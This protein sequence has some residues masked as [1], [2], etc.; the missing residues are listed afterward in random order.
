MPNFFVVMEN[1]RNVDKLSGYIIKLALFAIVVVLCWYFKNVLIYIAAAFVVS[2][3]GQPIMKVLRK[4]TIKKK[5]AP[6][7]LLAIVTLLLIFVFLILVITQIIPLVS[8]IIRDASALNVQSYFAENPLD[9][10][11][12]W[13]QATFP[14]LGKEFDLVT[15]I[16]DKLKGAVS[17]G[18]VSGFVS[19]V[20]SLVSSAFVGLFSVVFISFFFIKDGDMFEK[21]VCAL[22]PD[23]IEQ[24][25]KKTLHDIQQLLSRYFVGLL[26]EMLGVALV[27]FLGLWLVARINFNY[28]IGIAFIA[29]LLNVIP[30]VG[31]LMG[32][33]IGV[34]LGVVWKLGTGGGIGVHI[35]FFALIVLG[36]MLAAQLIDNFIYQPVIYSTSIKAHPLEIFIV[37]LMAGHIG[38][39][40]GMLV[41]IPCYTVVRVVAIRFF[42]RFKAIQR[43]IPDL[44]EEDKMIESEE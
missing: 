11:N 5:P 10:V 16:I 43:L 35:W 2:L 32:E 14:S 8:S 24:T 6:D 42:Y 31:P 25:T 4:I 7:W 33:L 30:Y 26:I 41:A 28:A 12:D 38:G 19:S 13:L 39:V 22:V 34:V 36:I 17:L 1:E 27:D 44:S 20:A 15:V 21:I 37:L 9:Q 18:N 29:G 40:A 3:V 23:K